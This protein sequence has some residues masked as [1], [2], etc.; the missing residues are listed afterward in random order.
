MA[1]SP[2]NSCWASLPP[3]YYHS[4]CICTVDWHQYIHIICTYHLS[5]SSTRYQCTLVDTGVC[6]N[7]ELV[8]CVYCIHT[9]ATVRYELSGCCSIALTGYR[10]L[11]RID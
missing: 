2:H 8:Q 11:N 7:M 1:L 6:R 3:D 5:S 9:G 10:E 4:I